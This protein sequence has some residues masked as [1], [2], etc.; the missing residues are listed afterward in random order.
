MSIA[1]AGIKALLPENIK[2]LSGPG[3][4]VCVTPSGVIDSILELSKNK[5]IIITTYGDMLKVPGSVKGES[6]AMQ[7][8]CLLYTSPSPRDS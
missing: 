7:K 6:L 4:P 3:C 2:L 1:R 8:A 5:N